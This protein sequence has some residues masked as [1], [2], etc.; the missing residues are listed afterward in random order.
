M[1]R[2]HLFLLRVY[3]RL[4]VGGRRFVVRRLFP[5]F[6]VGAMCIIERVDGHLLLVRH[7]YRRRWGVPGGLLGRGETPRDAAVREAREEVGLAVDLI[8]EPAVVVEPT[9]RR[10]DVVYRC[11]PAGGSSADDLRPQSPEIVEVRW[12][13]PGELPELQP[14]TATALVALARRAAEDARS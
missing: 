6:T 9:P 5:S 4:P 8:G 12:F 1:R 14:E 7:S 10:V 3:R 13:A 2:L 11:R